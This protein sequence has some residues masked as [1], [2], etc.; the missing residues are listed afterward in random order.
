MELV[1]LRMELVS[2]R[3]AL[4]NLRMELVSL[5]MALGNLRKELVSLL[6]ALGNLRMELVSLLMALGNLRK[7]LRSPAGPTQSQAELPAH[8]L[9]APLVPRDRHVR[10]T[11]PGSEGCGEG[12]GGAVPALLQRHAQPRAARSRPCTGLMLTRR[13]LEH[14]YVLFLSFF[15]FLLLSFILLNIDI[16]CDAYTDI[17]KQE[18]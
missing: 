4:G 18:H 5:L 9:H 13:I 2:L 11:R 12:D 6:M 8:K 14:G 10:V 17:I 7:E 15:L 3:M 1:S 16:K